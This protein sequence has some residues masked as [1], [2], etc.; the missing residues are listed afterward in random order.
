MKA[1]RHYG[2]W[3]VPA[4]QRSRI[5]CERGISLSESFCF[6]QASAPPTGVETMDAHLSD[7]GCAAAL[8]AQIAQESHVRQDY[9]REVEHMREQVARLEQAIMEAV[10]LASPAFQ[11]VINDLQALR[12]IAEYFGCDHCGRA[13]SSI[14]LRQCSAAD[15][16]YCGAVPGERLQWQANQTRRH[17]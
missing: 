15:G 5:R 3:C 16:C 10:K 13:G 7:L 11:Q 4:K 17:H 6:A 9:L 2:I 1:P 12:G 8:H 14:P